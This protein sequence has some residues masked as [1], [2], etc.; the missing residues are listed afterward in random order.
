MTTATAAPADLLRALAARAPGD[1]PPPSFRELEQAAHRILPELGALRPSIGDT[2]LV[3]V[4]SLTGHG[5]VLL[6]LESGNTTGTVKARTAYALLCA[7][8][9]RE[10]SR[11][12]R[13]VEYSGGS[14]AL[15]L[16]EFCSLLGLDLH[17]VVPDGTAERLRRTLLGHGATVSSGRPGTGFLGAMDEAVRVAEREGRQLLLQHCSTEAAA[18]HRDLTGAEIVA[19]LNARG[20]RPAA[21]S[22]AVGS[23]GTLLGTSLAVGAIWPDC[24]MLA[25][26]PAEAPHA[27]PLPPDGARRMSGTGGLGHG[28]PQPLLEHRVD[29]FQ[30]HTVDYRDALHAMRLLRS[31]YQLAVS[32][33]AAGAWLSASAAVDR[34]APGQ[35]AVAVAASRGTYEEWAHA[36]SEH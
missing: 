22:A 2:P 21:L 32:S 17:L 7:A 33:S 4:G 26:F 30:F 3:E 23:G 29:A 27:T 31:T 13:V 10:G 11:E 5:R 8:V 36:E 20:L 35:V 28:L 14:L 15:A 24:R 16:A 25:V 12:V 34:G 1:R 18:V 9:V 19:A 6:K